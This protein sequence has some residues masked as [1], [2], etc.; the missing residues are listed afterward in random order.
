L[1]NATTPPTGDITVPQSPSGTSVT[2]T[3]RSTSATND[4]LQ[5]VVRVES[6]QQGQT[7]L[8]SP[9]TI[10]GVPADQICFYSGITV[11]S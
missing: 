2:D 9:P 4:Y 11:T 5:D 6:P 7:A 3:D 1:G 10:A 8:T